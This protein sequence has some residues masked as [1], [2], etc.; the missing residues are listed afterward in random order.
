MRSTSSSGSSL[1]RTGQGGRKVTN[2]RAVVD[3]IGEVVPDE[4]DS[5]SS[6][7]WEREDAAK[8]SAFLSRVGDTDSV[9]LAG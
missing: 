9:D 3:R 1:E 5:G 2:I 4:G 6:A 8:E 7:C